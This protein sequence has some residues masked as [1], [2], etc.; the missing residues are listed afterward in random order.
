[1]GFIGKGNYMNEIK[2]DRNFFVG[3]YYAL[4]WLIQKYKETKI[5]PQRK[6]IY[7]QIF[8][9]KLNQKYFWYS[10]EMWSRVLDD[11][12]FKCCI[13]GKRAVCKI[14]YEGVPQGGSGTNCYCEEHML[15]T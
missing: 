15:K 9:K 7:K 2:P 14:I 4:K 10:Y 8:K 1:M 3:W 6:K 13:C 11:Y 5:I 12:H